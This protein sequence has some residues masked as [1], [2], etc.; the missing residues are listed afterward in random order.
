M[1]VNGRKF[2]FSEGRNLCTNLDKGGMELAA[3]CIRVERQC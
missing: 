1:R 2:K 3:M